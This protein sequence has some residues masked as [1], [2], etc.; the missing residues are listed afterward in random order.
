MPRFRGYGEGGIH[1][2]KGKVSIREWFLVRQI[3]ISPFKNQAE[4]PL[5]PGHPRPATQFA[6][7]SIELANATHGE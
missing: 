7:G 1:S 4:Y 5:K 3:G 2:N 6:R